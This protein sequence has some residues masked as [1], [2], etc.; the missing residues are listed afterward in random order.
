MA[1]EGSESL[2]TVLGGE[3]ALGAHRVSC[4]C[5]AVFGYLTEIEGVS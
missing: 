4:R 5:K 2:D 1:E 3:S